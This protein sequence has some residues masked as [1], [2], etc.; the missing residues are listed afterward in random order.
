MSDYCLT[1]CS[2]VDLTP[3][4]LSR[5]GIRFACCHFELDGEQYDDDMGKSMAAEELFRRMKNGAVT[6]T[7]QVNVQEY[8]EL[9]E[10]VLNE[11]RDVLH[12]TLSSGLSGGWNSACVARDELQSRYPD[13]KIYIVDSLGASSG[14]GLI[15]ETLADMKDAGADID[16][17]H[18]W[19]EANKLRMHH[20]F[21]SSDL[22]WYVLGGRISKVAGMVGSL[23][24]ICPLLNMNEAG[25][26]IPREK[27]RT[28]KKVKERL[29][30]MMEQHAENGSDYSGKCYLCHSLC[31]E[32]AA[33]VAQHI[34][35]RFPWLNGSVQ[36]YPIGTTIG[37]HTGPGTIS[38][39]FWGD[40]RGK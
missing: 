35:D 21:Y 4:Q 37:S 24:H 33:E 29:I 14:Y 40:Q 12:V 39:F 3:E 19:I 31:P 7:Q 20:W 13:R 30:Q 25:L 10:S 34:E 6:R 36:I 5:R 9:F 1:C 23:L 32:D 17:L 38:I 28:K 2:T 15:M 22:T 26:L 8:M 27:V 11:G 16:T 18:T